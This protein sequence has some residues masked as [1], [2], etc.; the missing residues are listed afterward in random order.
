MV[1]LLKTFLSFLNS[2]ITLKT[3]SQYIDAFN[4]TF[5]RLPFD[6]AIYY[7]LVY[8]FCY[9]NCFK[10]LQKEIKKCVCKYLS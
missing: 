3:L 10:L 5:F 6:F 2:G 9:P 4:G 8:Q 7:C 1:I